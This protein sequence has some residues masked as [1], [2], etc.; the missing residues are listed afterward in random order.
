MFFANNFR[1]KRDTDMQL[2]SLCFPRRDASDDMQ[3]ALFG[4]TRDL[5]LRSNFDLDLLGVKKHILRRVSTRET[6][7][8]HCPCSIFLVSKVIRENRILHKTA[9]LTFLTYVALPVDL[10]SIL[11]H[12]LEI[13]VRELSTGFFRSFLAII[14]SELMARFRKNVEFR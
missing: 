5:D 2:I 13:A 8:C 3:H 9:N 10:R 12:T 14:V 7:W 4:W 1:L 6:R 11:R